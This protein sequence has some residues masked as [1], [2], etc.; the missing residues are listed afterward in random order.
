[1]KKVGGIYF[2]ECKTSNFILDIPFNFE[3][4]VPNPIGKQPLAKLSHPNLSEKS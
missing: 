3:K 1:M 2:P 4:F